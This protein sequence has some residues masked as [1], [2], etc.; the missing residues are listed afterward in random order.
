VKFNREA[1]EMGAMTAALARK[2]H[3]IRDYLDSLTWDG[4]PRLDTML[5]RHAGASNSAWVR[6]VTAK[7]LI[8]AVARAHEPGAKVDTVLVLEGE[9]GRMKSSMLSA[10]AGEQYFSDNL[11]DVSH[12]DA[13]IHLNGKWIIE[14]AELDAIRKADN[15]R[16]KSFISRQV[17]Q[18]RPPYGRR[19]VYVPRSCIFIG[20]TNSSEYLTDASGGRR[21]WPVEIPKR[22][23]LN[24][25]RA[26]R[27]QLWA[28]ADARYRGGEAWHL[29]DELER[30]AAIE[31]ERRY[32]P[33][34]WEDVLREKL[35]GKHQTTFA[36]C[37][38]LLGIEVSKQTHVHSNEIAKTLKRIGF[39]QGPRTTGKDPN[40]GKNTR[41]RLYVLDQ[42]RPESEPVEEDGF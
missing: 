12:K 11:G 6:A 25:I 15:S 38:D 4:T 10:L 34:P 42:E 41:P 26:E 19:D 35:T 16:T 28:E 27:D 30:D 14:I 3:P 37:L 32:R 8:A 36:E 18:Y 29:D 31:Q 24:A 22:I 13:Q 17:D 20:T 40:T 23:E 2:I 1:V 21:F 7:T 33:H 39:K 9:Q 5:I